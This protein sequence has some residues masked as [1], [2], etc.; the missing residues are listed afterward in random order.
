MSICTKLKCRLRLVWEHNGDHILKWY[1][2]IIKKIT[3]CQKCYQ[4]V[5]YDTHPLS[6]RYHLL[7]YTHQLVLLSALLGFCLRFSGGGFLPF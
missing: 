1:Y 7:L 5:T 2:M 4:S 6:E 3:N